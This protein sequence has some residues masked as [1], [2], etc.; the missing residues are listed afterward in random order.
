M[1]LLLISDTHGDLMEINSLA[2]SNRCDAVIHAGDF[3]FYDEQSP[4]KLSDREINIIIRYSTLSTSE[5]NR[6]LDL[7][8]ESRKSYLQTDWSLSDL[9]KYLEDKCRFDIPVYT[10]WGNHEDASVLEKLCQKIYTVPNLNILHESN[11]F[12]DPGIRIFGLGGNIITGKKF[13]QSPFAGKGGKV[14]STISQFIKLI[15]QCKEARQKNEH[16]ILVSHVS[17]GKEPLVT[18]LGICLDADFV[19]SGHMD[20]KF[21]FC[22]SEFS[23]REFREATDR[24]DEWIEKIKII[25]NEL[26]ES[27]MVSVLQLQEIY[28]TK[29]MQLASPETSYQPP[30]WYQNMHCINLPDFGKGYAVLEFANGVC[31]F[32][33]YS[34]LK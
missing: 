13:F 19:V 7:P 27:A 3:G 32:E 34:Q 33:S 5:K 23:I 18:L 22:W 28:R 14:W 12:L 16:R 15:E 25:A 6:L 9:P 1:R 31:N 2:K 17:P 24:I 29:I 8:P 11:T 4:E 20:P 10:V 30:G 26:D 21:P